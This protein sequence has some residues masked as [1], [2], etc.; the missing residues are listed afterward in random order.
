LRRSWDSAALANPR[1]RLALAAVTF[2]VTFFLRTRDISRHFWLLGDQIRDWA[3]ALGTLNSLPLVGP[4]THVH[5]YTI[6][7][8]FYWILWSIRVVVGPFFQNLPHGGGIGQALLQSAVDVL[9]LIAVWKRTQSVCLGL[10]TIVLLAT[11]PFDLALSAVVWN[12]IVGSILAKAAIALIL[13]DWH[14][15]SLV[16]TALTAAVAWSAV[17]SYTGTI[18]VALSVFVALLMEPLTKR[19]WPVFGRRAVVIAGTVIALQLP[20]VFHQ[21]TTR[22][23]DSGMTAVT[24]SLTEIVTGREPLRLKPSALTYVGALTSIQRVPGSTITWVSI[25]LLSAACVAFRYRRDASLLSILLLPQAATILGYALWFGDLDSYYYLSLVPAALVTMV[26]ALATVM[27][28]RIRGAVA[29]FCLAG[30]IAIVPARASTAAT[31]FSMP[32]YQVLVA[33]ST[34][35]AA[36]RQPI[37]SIRTAFELPPTS[38]PEF[39]FRVLGGHI[40][41]RAPWSAVILA[42]GRV[43]YAQRPPGGS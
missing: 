37:Q 24:S 2:V 16:R 26:L 38:D 20:Y 42:D 17:Q 15:G 5:G 14:R 11:A 25:L 4:P 6:G 3:I 28:T 19:D 30:A 41:R 8:A 21:M 23:D 12:P 32:Q 22:F 13:L 43:E 29:A 1:L 33:G 36:R 40:D 18:F 9:L 10:T 31:L 39:I 7:P 35:I 34:H 27:P